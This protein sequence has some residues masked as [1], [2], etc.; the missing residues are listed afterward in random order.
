M[1]LYPKRSGGTFC[2]RRLEII[3]PQSAYGACSSG[4]KIKLVFFPPNLAASVHRN[5]SATGA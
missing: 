4:E 3:F 5:N 2:Y 1:S